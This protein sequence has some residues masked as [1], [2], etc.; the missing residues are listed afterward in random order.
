MSLGI[1]CC[2]LFAFGTVNSQQVTG[3]NGPAKKLSDNAKQEMVKKNAPD[4]KKVEHYAQESGLLMLPG[5]V[6]TGNKATDKQN[7]RATKTKFIQDNPAEYRK[8]MQ[9]DQSKR[10]GAQTV[11]ARQVIGHG[12]TN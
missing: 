1:C 7:Y 2:F 4:T 10:T 3:N 8:A 11:T 6:P 9:A 12:L 5:F